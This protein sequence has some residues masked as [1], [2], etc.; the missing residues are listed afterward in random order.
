[1]DGKHRF[2]KLARRLVF[3]ALLG[4]AVALMRVVLPR[5]GW[6]DW[7]EDEPEWTPKPAPVAAVVVESKPARRPFRSHRLVTSFGLVAVFF[8]AAT[9]TAGAGD[10]ISKAL[11]PARCAA[12]MQTT[13]ED[14]SICAQIAQE[15]ALQAA[16]A[17]AE[18]AAAE[19]AAAPE[20]AAPEA[21]PE[22]LP[23]SETAAPEAAAEPSSETA[24]VDA[25]AAASAEGQTAEAPDA[26][27]PDQAPDASAP[28]A[29][30]EAEED[31]ILEPTG[32]SAK[33]AKGSSRHWVVRRAKERRTAPVEH[34]GGA[35]TIWLNR[36][37]GDPTPPAKR[38]SPKFAKNLQ[39][40]SA[41]NGVSW[42]LVLGV[43]RAEGARDRT[44]ATIK[45]L[46]AL[47]RGLA[48]RGAAGSE[49]N[50]ALALS[51]RTGFADRAVALARYNRVVGLDGLVRGLEAAK[52]R[53][54]QQ[55]LNDPRA[56][57]YSAGRDDLEQG[58]IDVRTVV[59]ISYL[60][61]SFGQVT[62]SSLFSGHRKYARPGVVSAHIY[63]H[64]VD[65]AAVANTPIAG[66]QQ[67]G[68][69]TEKA[70]RSILLLPVELQPRQ[71]ISLIGMGGPSFPLADHDDHI[72]VG[73]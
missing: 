44:P 68:S 39:R 59:V 10:M 73:F 55:L 36:E 62:V 25:E 42:A 64:A 4:W 67:P 72:H 35:A 41:V 37:L 33:P 45:E 24:S 32:P 17:D 6:D 52:P 57:I 31:L 18:Q 69:V 11:D 38:L 9:F 65:I 16:Q 26:A 46:N 5:R 50:A 14:E 2:W 40:I 23:A 27:S 28:A 1:M 54:T 56:E 49:W 70:V 29:T 60:A 53:L 34:E 12:L 19:A 58:R 61:E 7:S 8:A 3:F 47:A 22:A 66:H 43:L 13:G 51:G 30:S 21:A 71:V 48:A 15:E 63:G 20:A